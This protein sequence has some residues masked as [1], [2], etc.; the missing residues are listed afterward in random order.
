MGTNCASLVAYLLLYS[1]GADFEYLQKNKFKKQKHPLISLFVIYIYIYNVL[2]F[3]SVMIILMLFIQN[4]LRLKTLQILQNWLI[5]L[6]FVWSLISLLS[7]SH[8]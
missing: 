8:I 2:S 4:N 7:L 3:K 5:I 1:Y 6:A